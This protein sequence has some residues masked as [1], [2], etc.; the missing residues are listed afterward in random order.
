VQFPPTLPHCLEYL[1]GSVIRT[2]LCRTPVSYIGTSGKSNAAI[3]CPR[4]PIGAT[5]WRRVGETQWHKWS[6]VPEEWRPFLQRKRNTVMD[7]RPEK[8]P[9][10][11]GI[12][13]D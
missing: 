7:P 13:D 2:T 12:K 10:D 4:I 11:R 6:E 8:L 3:V 5:R 1:C 9:R